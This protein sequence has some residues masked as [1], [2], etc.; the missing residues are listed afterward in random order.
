MTTPNTNTIET[1]IPFSGF[2]ES[3]HSG[4]FDSFL[5]SESEYYTDELK[6]DRELVDSLIHSFSFKKEMLKEY[7]EKYLEY[8]EKELEIKLEYSAIQSPKF[9]NYGT[10]CLFANIKKTDINRLYV[11]THKAY[12]MVVN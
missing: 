7:C 3:W 12:L 4:A 6:L 5:E 1:A 2:Y 10:D 9:Y 8:I 11:T